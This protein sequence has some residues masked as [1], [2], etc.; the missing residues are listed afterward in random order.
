M[1]P[2]QVEKAWVLDDGNLMKRQIAF[3]PALYKI[4]DEILV[5]A[6]DNK[7]RDQKMSKSVYLATNSF[8]CF[9]VKISCILFPT[10]TLQNAGD[11][12]PR[13][14]RDLGVEQWQGH[15]D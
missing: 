6:A 13:K 1:Q 11:D 12:K 14:M 2:A 4:F 8:T 5:N 15:T 3:V 7:Q 10:T 9:N